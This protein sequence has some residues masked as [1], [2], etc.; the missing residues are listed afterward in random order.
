MGV[1]YLDNYLNFSYAEFYYGIGLIGIIRFL[2]PS[3]YNVFLY[4][5]MFLMYNEYKK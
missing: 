4:T 2:K 5:T 1:D 3:I